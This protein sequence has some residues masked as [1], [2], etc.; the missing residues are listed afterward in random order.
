MQPEARNKWEQGV[1]YTALGAY[2]ADSL[3]TRTVYQGIGPVNPRE[4]VDVSR[5]HAAPG[6]HATVY[7]DAQG[8][9]QLPVSQGVT[10]GKLMVSSSVIRDGP[11]GATVCTL[12][13]VDSVLSSFTRAFAQ[14]ALPGRTATW[15][16]QLLLS[17]IHI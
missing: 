8:I 15:F 9:G 5:V 10:R 3:I 2:D 6:V 14:R 13:H 4:F 17:L 1:N 12:N 11:Q 16:E 7:I